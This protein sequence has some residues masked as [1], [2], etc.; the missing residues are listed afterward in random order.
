MLNVA[1]PEPLNANSTLQAENTR[2][3]RPGPPS[4]VRMPR[5]P[6]LYAATADIRENAYSAASRVSVEFGNL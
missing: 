6:P 2:Q 1:R 3:P 5:F 4:Q